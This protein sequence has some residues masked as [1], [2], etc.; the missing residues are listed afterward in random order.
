MGSP[1][2]ELIE[3]DLLLEGVQRQFGLD[4]RGYCRP[5]L[6]R[7]LR[8]LVR[9]EGLP[10]ISALQAEVLHD[11]GS[12]DK[13]LRV[14]AGQRAELFDD[15]D[16]YLA[17]RRKII[18]VL[19]THPTARV[20]VAGCGAGEAAWSLAMV[21]DEE[22]LLGRSRIY[23]TDATEAVLQ[24]ARTGALAVHDA[25]AEGRWLRAG[26]EGSLSRHL[27]EDRG[28]VQVKPALKAAVFFAQHNLA[29]DGAF[30][31]FNVVLC[32]NV[33]LSFNRT[34]HNRVHTRLHESLGRFG[35][36]GLGRKESLTRTPHAA[37]YEEVEGG[38]RL[39]RRLS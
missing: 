35:V 15:P 25:A 1:E 17:F 34:L 6:L 33:L 20:W 26:G 16:F 8:A 12:L 14:S 36:L 3:V 24:T 4:L 2:L 21:L 38:G 7:R 13:L 30:N 39:Y 19:R 22:G 31:E 10:S 28:T 11:E 29:T 18:P 23:A 37:E 5:T 9:A 32:R 27:I